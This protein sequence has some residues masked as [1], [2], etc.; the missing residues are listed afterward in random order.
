MNILYKGGGLSS[1]DMHKK[2][3][4]KRYPSVPESQFANKRDRK[5]PIPTRADAVDALRLAKMHGHK[6]IV[7]KVYRKYPEL[8]K[9]KK[10]KGG[11]TKYKVL[12]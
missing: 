5:Y 8:R 4:K 3:S 10:V 1:K 2:G 7:D 6:N 12:Y 9:V 11:K